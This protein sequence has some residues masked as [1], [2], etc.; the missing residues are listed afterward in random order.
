MYEFQYDYVKPKFREKAKLSLQLLLKRKLERPLPR[1]KS[2]C[3]TGLCQDELD[4]KIL[5][6]FA[7]RPKHIALQQVIITNVKKWKLK[8]EDYKNDLEESQLDYEINDLENSKQQ[9]KRIHK[10]KKKF[11]KNNRLILKSQQCL[12]AR[13]T[14]QLLKNLIRLH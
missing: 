9:S 10:K 7:L 13:N 5:T 14:T 8:F 12:E 6:F 2:K 3:V 11:L 4:G 1:K